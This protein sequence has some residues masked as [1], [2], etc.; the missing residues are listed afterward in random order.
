MQTKHPR[1]VQATLLYLG[2][3]NAFPGGWALF[4]PRSF[5][6]SFPGLGRVWVA[7]DGPY[8]EHLIRDAGGFF[9][10]LALLCFLAFASPRLVSVRAVALCL[11]MFSGPHLLYHL[12]HLHMLPLIDQIGNVVTLSVGALLPLLLLGYRDFEK[13]SSGPVHDKPISHA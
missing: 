11:L 5:Y 1:W 12:T 6:E 9:L 2:I 4:L 7:V 10:A 3:T 8:N 13:A